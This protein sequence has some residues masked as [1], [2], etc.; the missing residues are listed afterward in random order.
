MWFIFGLMFAFWGR[1]LPAETYV[2]LLV[3][4]T[5]MLALSEGRQ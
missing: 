2:S 5:A 3:L 1:H 4:V